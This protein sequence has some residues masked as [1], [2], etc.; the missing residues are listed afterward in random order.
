MANFK[1]RC[2]VV[3][4]VADRFK[5]CKVG[6]AFIFGPRTAEGMCSRAFAAVYP[7]AVA[8]RF[9][10]KIPWERDG[11]FVDVTCPDGDVT[12]RLTRIRENP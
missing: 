8:M 11:D 10:D 12:Y 1:I 5:C 7:V 4:I 2:E 9:S 3:R 6:Q